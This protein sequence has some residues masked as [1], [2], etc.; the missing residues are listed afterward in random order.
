M[1]E[2]ERGFGSGVGSGVRV[3]REDRRRIE[4]SKSKRESL[5]AEANPRRMR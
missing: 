4:N 5:N 2:F 3:G 1:W